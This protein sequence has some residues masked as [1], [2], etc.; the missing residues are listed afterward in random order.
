VRT[1]QYITGA[2][3]PTTQDLYTRQCQR[4][5]LKIVK[6]CSL[7]YRMASGTGMPSLGTRGF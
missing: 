5:A 4:K 7:C 3:L 1:A 2:K 6:D